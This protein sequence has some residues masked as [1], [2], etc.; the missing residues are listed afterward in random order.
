[1]PDFQLTKSVACSDRART[2]FDFFFLFGLAWVLR[3]GTDHAL[4]STELSP[5]CSPRS[6]WRGLH[7]SKP[8]C[9]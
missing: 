8:W 2:R 3:R 7:A 6:R 5:T 4:S 9:R 1:M